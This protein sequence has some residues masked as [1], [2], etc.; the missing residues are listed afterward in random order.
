MSLIKNKGWFNQFTEEEL[1]LALK[2]IEERKKNDRENAQKAAKF[3]EEKLGFGNC[4]A[5]SDE[6]NQYISSINSTY[7]LKLIHQTYGPYLDQYFEKLDKMPEASKT[8]VVKQAGV[9]GIFAED[10]IDNKH[11]GKYQIKTPFGDY[12]IWFEYFDNHF[13]GF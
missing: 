11:H 13:S 5:E 2:Q 6:I 4:I 7:S 12:K 8:E 1:E 3:L 9:S 10:S